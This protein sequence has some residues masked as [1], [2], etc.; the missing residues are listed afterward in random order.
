MQLTR[1]N[2]VEGRKSGEGIEN[3]NESQLEPAWKSVSF[4]NES[5][6]Q[7]SGDVLVGARQKKGEP[8]PSPSVSS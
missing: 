2:L 8:K 4:W 6:L 5:W 1:G 3:A 7:M